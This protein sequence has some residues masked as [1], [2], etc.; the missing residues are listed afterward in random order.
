[1]QKLI[2]ISTY[3]PVV[4][5][6]LKYNA[7]IH[8]DHVNNVALIPAE[9]LFNSIN[10][11]QPIR[12]KVILSLTENK[13]YVTVISGD[14]LVNP[15]TYLLLVDTAL[16]ICKH[17]SNPLADL[18]A[19]YFAEV[20]EEI[21]VTNIVSIG[22]DFVAIV[23]CDALISLEYMASTFSENGWNDGHCS[24]AV[25]IA[26]LKKDRILRQR[27]GLKPY[28]G[29]EGWFRI[30]PTTQEDGKIVTTVLFTPFG[31]YQ[32][33]RKYLGKASTVALNTIANMFPASDKLV[34][35]SL[36]EYRRIC[37]LKTNPY[38]KDET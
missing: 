25:L 36:L 10:I 6:E 13:D 24:Q 26:L 28:P 14:P 33:I 18:A 4:E 27:N 37:T 35:N 7:P 22:Q 5:G 21:K 23:A 32:A 12:E 31:V 30:R 1:M 29:Y 16:Q 38:E 17:F 15:D 34:S 2:S 19:R 20:L 9:E 11:P 3:E 8:Y